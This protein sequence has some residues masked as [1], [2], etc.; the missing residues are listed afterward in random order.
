MTTRT[1]PSRQR[2][3]A[4]HR[5]GLLWCSKCLKNLTPAEL[6]IPNDM[7]DGRLLCY[8]CAPKDALRWT[9]LCI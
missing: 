1:Q 8:D 2:I 6:W 5:Q 3:E 4:L 9:D 7:Q